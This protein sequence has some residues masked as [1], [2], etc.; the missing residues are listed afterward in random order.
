MVTFVELFLS[1]FHYDPIDSHLYN[2]MQTLL[3]LARGRSRTMRYTE[4]FANLSESTEL[5]GIVEPDTKV[6]I[7]R[8]A[9]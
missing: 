1:T 4:P 8:G 7:T 9:A 2:L 3:Q 5:G 6:D